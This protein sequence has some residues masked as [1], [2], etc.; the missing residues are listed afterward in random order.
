MDIT[1][2][3]IKTIHKKCDQI[4]DTT[5][6]SLGKQICKQPDFLANGA[7]LIDRREKKPVEIRQVLL[8]IH[9]INVDVL[10]IYST[11]IAHIDNN[12]ILPTTEQRI[13][14]Q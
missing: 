8:S 11:Y 7:D 3:Q 6:T 14:V 10:K 5:R 1:Y 13:I 9:V 2:Y 12:S 4:L